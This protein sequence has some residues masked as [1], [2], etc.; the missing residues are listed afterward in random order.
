MPTPAPAPLRL[1]LIEDDPADASLAEAMLA[2]ANA[3]AEWTQAARLADVN[4]GSVAGWADCILTDLGLP[5]GQG[6]DVVRTILRRAPGV[7]VVVISGNSDQDM[8][9]AA[10]RE[11]A[12]DFVIK[13]RFDAPLL[14]KT[15]RYAVERKRLE[16]ELEQAQQLARLGGLAG[17]IAHHFNNLLGVILNSADF[18]AD[19]L[20]GAPS[21]DTGYW[22]EARGDVRRIQHAGRRAAELTRLLTVFAEQDMAR[23][24]LLILNDVIV[25][26]R[27]LLV[28]RLGPGITLDLDL[29]TDLRPVRIDQGHI[30]QL[31]A[32]LADNARDAISGPG[33]VV[34]STANE[35]AGPPEGAGPPRSWVRVQVRDCGPGIGEGVIGRV[36]DPFFTTKKPGEGTGLGLAVAHAIVTR[37]GGRIELGSRPGAGTTVTMLFPAAPGPGDLAT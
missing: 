28:S 32:S 23:A 26:T 37:W 13:G 18:V 35:E 5:D 33:C 16:R 1:L 9:L 14:A 34:I 21:A 20:D 22:Q 4:F 36:F 31:L 11:G 17:G 3:A 25:R 7:P 6:L 2:R 15:V 24:E 10:V 27:A 19:A 8:A 29:T 12:Q 30:Q